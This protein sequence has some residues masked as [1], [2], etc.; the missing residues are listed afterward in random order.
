MSEKE[1]IVKIAEARLPKFVEDAYESIEKMQG[2]AKILLDSKLVPIHFYE[3]GADQKPD[4]TKGK[5][6]AV[7]AVLIQGYQ[8]Q[9]PPLTALQHI[10]PVNGLLSIKGDL[11]KSMIFNS[12]KLKAESWK[13]VEVGTIE[14]ENLKVSITATRSDNGQT[15]TRSFSVNE[16]K[17]AGLWVTA[18]QVGGADGWK[19]KAS[20]WYKYP[21]RMI[22]YRALGFIARDLFPDVMAGIYTTEE[23]ADIPQDQTVIIDQGNGTQIVLPDKEF[24]KDRSSKIA[25]RAVDKIEKKE[26]EPIPQP[27]K[28][29]IEYKDVEKSGRITPA[30]SHDKS[31]KPNPPL[32]DDDPFKTDRSSVEYM[33]GVKVVRNES[34]AIVN[35]EEINSAGENP[36]PPEDEVINPEQPVKQDLENMETKD[37]LKIVNAD[38]NMAEATIL[39]GGKNTNKK[40]RE[41]IQANQQGKLAELVAPHL[42]EEEQPQ[43]TLTEE[44]AGAGI[45]PNTEFD[46]I[47]QKIGAIIIPPF[48]KGNER[49]FGNTK[50]L[51]DSL[52][53]TIPRISNERFLE[54]QKDIPEFAKYKNKEDFC[55]FA[56]DNEIGIL[57]NKNIPL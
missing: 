31:D 12:G 2:F 26:F 34:G 7:V 47:P 28:K 29:G 53:G 5:L 22:N 11:A 54:L 9:L 39:I 41:I 13:E 37:L 3:K 8:L 50:Q 45:K 21:A 35:M 48:N 42:K 49:D 4:F 43:E 25:K 56:N 40:L 51:Y 27:D 14:D 52:S 36:P 16:A 23:A 15:L 33:N 1:G 24:A 19:Y 55:K 6:E 46:R 38:A 20:A 32:E 44:K 17:R 30:E 18:Q 57:L 10:I